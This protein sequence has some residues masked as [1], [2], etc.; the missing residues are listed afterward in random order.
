MT[1]RIDGQYADV[2]QMAEEND[3]KSLSYGFESHH[4]YSN[5]SVAQP[6]RGT[7]LRSKKLRVQIPSDVP[8]ATVVELAD[9]ADMQ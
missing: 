3:S 1:D 2:S 8:Y 7:C 6:G 5:A 9:T 4:R